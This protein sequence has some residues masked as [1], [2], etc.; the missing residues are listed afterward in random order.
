MYSEIPNI[1]LNS[2]IIIII[3]IIIVITIIISSSLSSSLSSSSSFFNN[4]SDKCNYDNNIQI[5]IK[6]HYDKTLNNS[7]YSDRMKKWRP[8]IQIIAFTSVKQSANC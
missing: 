8:F 4:T 6:L 2:C 5:Y 7:M 1:D 3:I